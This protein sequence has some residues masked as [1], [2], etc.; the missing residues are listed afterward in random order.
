MH[1][2]IQ[3]HTHEDI[4][5]TFSSIARAFWITTILSIEDFQPLIKKIF[6]RKTETP[7]FNQVWDF[8]KY[9]KGNY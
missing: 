6:K 8:A 3:G 4:D 2:L 9:F 1:C 7:T 5:Q